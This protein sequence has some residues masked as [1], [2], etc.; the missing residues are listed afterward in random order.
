MR[1]LKEDVRTALPKLTIG[2]YKTIYADPPWD[3][4]QGGKNAVSRVSVVT[5]KSNRSPIGNT[6]YIRL[7]VKELLALGPAIQRVAAP[8]SH[9]YFWTVNKT[10]PD[11]AKIIEAWGY[12]WVTMITWDKGRPGI[13]KYFQGVTE[14]CVFAVR[15]SVPY[16]FVDG[17]MQQGRTLVAEQKTDHSRKP[18]A[19]CEVIERV[20]YG[21]YLE[22]FGRRVPKNWDAIGLELEEL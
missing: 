15:G 1:R 13:A 6:P 12:R 3:W 20:S 17:K 22:L 7:S 2:R 9:L 21:P 14:H 16:K 8:N 4:M 10:V 5:G 11:A 18:V 19:M